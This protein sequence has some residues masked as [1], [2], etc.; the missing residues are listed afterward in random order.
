L[1]DEPEPKPVF[2]SRLEIMKAYFKLAVCATEE[3][4]KEPPNRQVLGGNP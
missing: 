2:S 3:Q 1:S 4:L